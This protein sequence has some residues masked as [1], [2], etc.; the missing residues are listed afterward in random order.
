MSIQHSNVSF[1]V[2]ASPSGTPSLYHGFREVYAV[3][4]DRI[5]VVKP[6]DR[7]YEPFSKDEDGITEEYIYELT[8][9]EILELLKTRVIKHLQRLGYKNFA[10]YQLNPITLP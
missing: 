7:A 2:T 8:D 1:L 10:I 9:E 6:L 4:R 3:E 5:S